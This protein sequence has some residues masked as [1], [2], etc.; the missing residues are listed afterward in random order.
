MHAEVSYMHVDSVNV[1]VPLGAK[2]G[3]HVGQEGGQREH[4]SEQR[5]RDGQQDGILGSEEPRDPRRREA[6]HH[7]GA[8][9][10]TVT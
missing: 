10:E 8:Q 4:A 1:G 9:E 5:I 6:Q 3:M 2:P 7:P